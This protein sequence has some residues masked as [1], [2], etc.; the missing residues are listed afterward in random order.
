M[1]NKGSLPVAQ[2]KLPGHGRACPIH[3]LKWCGNG[4]WTF[5]PAGKQRSLLG[6]ALRSGGT[7][8]PSPA[9]SAPGACR[10]GRRRLRWALNRIVRLLLDPRWVFILPVLHLAGCIATA[11]TGLEWLPVIIS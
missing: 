2:R 6:E 7:D 1:K 5:L 10:G 9:P 11:L 3:V 8:R 4:E